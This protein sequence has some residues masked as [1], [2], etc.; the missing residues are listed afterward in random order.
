MTFDRASRSLGIV[1]SAG[2]GAIR[3]FERPTDDG[4]ASFNFKGPR[5]ILTNGSRDRIA[6]LLES[7]FKKTFCSEFAVVFFTTLTLNSG[8]FS[9]K[10]LQRA[11]I[12]MVYAD[13]FG[14]FARPSAL[15]F[16]QDAFEG[17]NT[18]SLITGTTS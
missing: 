6:T 4:N 10:L 12:F 5:I 8:Y 13:A 2:N 1:V 15:A 7:A 18:L 9:V 11:T 14:R 3:D 16:G 17:E